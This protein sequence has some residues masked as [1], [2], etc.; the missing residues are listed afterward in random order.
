MQ[1]ET[2]NATYLQDIETVV[3]SYHIEALLERS[4]LG[5]VFR[6]R[7]QGTHEVV[8]LKVLSS[9]GCRGNLHP[10]E[11]ATTLM[12]IVHPNVA[13][14]YDAWVFGSQIFLAM[15]WIEGEN[16]SALLSRGPVGYERVYRI[17]E[18]LLAGL[19]AGHLAGL[20]HRDIKPASLT[21]ATNGCVKILDFGMHGPP[22]A[23]SLR[24][25]SSYGGT[26]GYM[27]PE[28]LQGEVVDTRAD[29]YAAAATLYALASGRLP[30]EEPTLGQLLGRLQRERAPLLS[31]YVPDAPHALVQALDRGL[32]RDRDARFATAREFWNAL[33]EEC[34]PLTPRPVTQPSVRWKV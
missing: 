33:S 18:Q 21:D 34:G 9:D 2:T 31:S 15:E 32:M 22:R 23:E 1:S 7:H 12:S 4:V 20:V 6:A 16:L 14:L 3:G 30:F 13:R 17:A 8:A 10:L 27:A 28:Q 5:S 29:L 26:P 19:E 25:S 24:V 11:A